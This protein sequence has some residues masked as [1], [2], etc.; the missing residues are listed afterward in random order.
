MLFAGGRSV[1]LATDIVMG[2]ILTR[3]SNKPAGIQGVDFTKEENIRALMMESMRHYAPVTTINYWERSGLGGAW[4]HH[5]PCLHKALIDPAEF[6]E[7][8]EFRLN[9]PGQDVVGPES[10]SIAWADFATVDGDDGHPDSHSC[11]A[12]DL[13]IEMVI[14]FAL[15]CQAAG[16]VVENDD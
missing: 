4:E 15:E 2:Y 5:C 7:P 6:P 9:R 8:K 16:F 10:N 11:P 13:S 3:N 12:K 1:P 14:A